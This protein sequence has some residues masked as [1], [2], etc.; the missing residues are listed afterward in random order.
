MLLNFND[1]ATHIHHHYEAQWKVLFST[2]R[3]RFEHFADLRIDCYPFEATILQK[4]GD[5]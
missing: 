1:H 3:S 4:I 5:L 2:H